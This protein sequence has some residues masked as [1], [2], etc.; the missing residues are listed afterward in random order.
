MDKK[1]R[2]IKHLMS[3]LQFRPKTTLPK[4]ELRDAKLNILL[5]NKKIELDIFIGIN[6]KSKEHKERKEV[7]DYYYSKGFDDSQIMD[8]WLSSY[9]NNWSTK[10]FENSMPK[11]ERRDNQNPVTNTRNFGSGGGNRGW[12]RVPSKKHINRYKNFLKLF[13]WYEENNI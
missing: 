6:P 5:R 1:E 4:Q 10:R 7:F 12:L 8:I 13:P 3:K 2:R 9:R 11:A